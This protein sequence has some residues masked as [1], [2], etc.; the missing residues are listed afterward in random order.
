MNSIRNVQFAIEHEITRQIKVLEAGGTIPSETRSYDAANDHTIRLRVKE[1]MSDYRY[2]SEP[3][4]SPLIVADEW[5]NAIRQTMPM[6]PRQ[7]FDKF[8]TTYQLPAYDATVLS[9]NKYIAAFYESV[10]QLTVHYKA[11]SNWIMGPVKSYLNE[12]K[13]TID[14]FPLSPNALAALIELVAHKKVSF[15]VASQRIYPVLL[16]TPKKSPEAIAQELGLLHERDDAQLEAWIDEVVAAF[17]DK[18]EA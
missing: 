12:L 15:S 10:C 9:G 16:K 17:P 6:L 18:V 3:D 8:I 13:V 7:C 2:F 14:Q 4:L 1:G 11:A 5:V